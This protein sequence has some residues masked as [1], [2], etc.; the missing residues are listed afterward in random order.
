MA[1]SH[2]GILFSRSTATWIDG[3]DEPRKR[4]A[5][6]RKPQKASYGPKTTRVEQANAWRQKSVG[7]ARSGQRTAWGDAGH[8][9][10]LRVVLKMPKIS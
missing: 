9:E 5:E 3:M 1:R 4:C 8:T 10:L 7:G 6:R 2:D